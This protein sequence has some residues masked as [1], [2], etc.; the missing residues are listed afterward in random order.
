MSGFD[1][2]MKVGMI[3]DGTQVIDARAV[4]LEACLW[5]TGISSIV[6]LACR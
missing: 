3:V 5:R 2:A 4:G 6:Q 1:L